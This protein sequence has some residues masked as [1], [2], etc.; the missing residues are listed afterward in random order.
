M[1]EAAAGRKPHLRSILGYY[2]YI[3]E[4]FFLGRGEQGTMV[5][6]SSAFAWDQWHKLAPLAN[7]CTRMD[8]QVTWP[9]EEEPGEYIREM[10][11]EGA[12]YHQHGHRK[13]EVELR[14]TPSGAKMLTVG[15]RQSEIYGRMYDKYRES[16]QEEYKG[17]VRWEIEVKGHQAQD[18]NAYML[19]NRGEVATTRAIV[20]NFW[21]A[22]GMTPFWDTFGGVEK[23]PP[24]KRTRTDESKLAWLQT[25]VKPTIQT[26][27]DNGKLTETIRT[28]FDGVLTEA[29]ISAILQLSESV[30]DD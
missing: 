11:R 3:G 4:H 17:C 29:Q 23:Q 22:R 26:L 30:V 19:E 16:K 15:S 14:D 6:A 24:T 2:G 9:L 12:V 20:K 18:L 27:K 10:Y 8:L 1:R 7:H 28:L 25:Q 13:A 21:E 5:Q